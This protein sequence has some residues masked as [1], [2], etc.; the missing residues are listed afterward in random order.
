MFVKA[1]AVAARRAPRELLLALLLWLRRVLALWRRRRTSRDRGHQLDERC[2]IYIPPSIYK[3][4]DPLIYCQDF[5]M[6]QGLAVTW[7]NPDIRLFRDDVP[8]PSSAL[9]PDTLYEVRATIWNGSF[10]AP[11]LGLPVHL[12]Y[13]SFGIGAGEHHV[14]STSVDLPIK[15]VAGHPATAVL[16][17]RTP[18]AAGHYCL[19]VRLEWPDD[20]N[21]NNNLGQ[22]NTTVRS[23]QS[24]AWFEV[25]V[26]NAMGYR[27]EFQLTVDAYEQ[28][29]VDPCEQPRKPHPS[30]R[31]ESEARWAVARQ[32]HGWDTFPVPLGWRVT[33]EPAELVLDALEERVVR[34]GIEPP[35]GFRGRKGFNV[36]GFSEGSLVGGVTLYVEV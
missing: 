25:P 9:V 35:D 5:L 12:S 11:A 18:D 15:G 19:R 14:G 36:N 10:D 4:P 17:W 20:A 23:P 3:R 16:H 21:P 7:D 22:E 31:A 6:A 27:R 32:T 8:V 2:G 30:R 29:P 24:P 28:R 26:R 34:V 1:F 13:L 33:V